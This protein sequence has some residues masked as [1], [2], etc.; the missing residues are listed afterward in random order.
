MGIFRSEDMSL[1]EISVPKDNAWEIMNTLGNLNALHFVDLNSKEQPFALTYANWVKRCDDTLRRI[2]SIK[3]ECKRLNVPLRKPKDSKTFL[4]NLDAIYRSRK[5]SNSLYFEEIEDKIKTKENFIAQ[6]IDLLRRMH[7]DLNQLIQYKTVLSKSAS[8]I[9][10]SRLG[11][12]QSLS[13]SMS[14][15]GEGDVHESLVNIGE[16]SIGHIAGTILKEEQDR[17]N[18]LIFRATRGNAIVCFKEFTKP[19]VN[20]FGVEQM[21]TVYV[22]VFQEGEFIRDRICKICDSFLG[23]RY[24]IPESGF[25][26]KLH[27]LET[28]IRDAR[29][30]LANTREET[31]KFLVMTNE[32]E[33]EDSS[34][35]I[36]YEWFIVKERNIFITLNKLKTGDRLFFG[37]YW[38]PNTKLRIVN[39]EVYKMKENRNMHA[40]QIVRREIHELEPPTY[41]YLNDFTE[42]FQEITDTYGVPS[43]KEVNSGMFNLVTFPFLYGVMFGDIGHGGLLFMLGAALVM[44]PSTFS[45]IGLGVM[46]RVRYLLLLLGFFSCFIGWCYNDFMSIPVDLPHGSCYEN[47]TNEHGQVE[48]FAL[49]DDCVYPIGFD[50]KW[51]LGTNTLTFFNSM[52]MKLSVIL[53][54]AQMSLG[55]LMKGFNA[56]HFGRPIEFVFE[57]IPQI[58]LMSALFGYMDYLIIMKWLTNWTDN[59]ARAPGIISTMIGMFL[60]F[61]EIPE[62]TDALVVSAEYQQWLSTTL[63]LVALTCVPAMLLV[64]PLWHLYTHPSEGAHS[65]HGDKALLAGND[66][67]AIEMSDIQHQHKDNAEEHELLINK[68]DVPAKAAA[69]K[70][71]AARAHKRDVF[72]SSQVD[73][74]QFVESGSH[75][76]HEFSEIFIHQLIETIEFVLG[77]VSNTASY[78]RLWALSLAHSQLAEVFYEKLLGGVAFEANEGRGSGLLLFLLFPAFFSF[79]F[80]VLMCM[81]SMECFLHCLRLH[82]VEFQNKFYKGNGYRF[83]PFSYEKT[84]TTYHEAQE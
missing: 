32:M 49:K 78:L 61:G 84:I 24:E 19:I 40:P 33:N 57:F 37:L 73:L 21:K 65:E 18:R 58:I 17:F 30:I 74:L 63:L 11:G 10:G 48:A 66:N 41:F 80:F 53:G 5:R 44:F 68:D 81:D 75:E 45:N 9:G 1:Y 83:A 38:I 3:A 25:T 70:G 67:N 34:A 62:G 71:R 31:R 6:Q 42:P 52:K 8:V 27:D 56:I 77:T 54:V 14:S 29:K 26:D 69:S 55:I 15:N 36:V 51:Y 28:K 50:P 79:T 4:S 39:D 16:I 43:Y 72:E 47:V 76:S 35:V 20:Y 82:W 13:V 64:K 7:D 2:Q 46:V 12:D 59:T 60:K 22:I 23:D